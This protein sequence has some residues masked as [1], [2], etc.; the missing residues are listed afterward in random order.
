[1]PNT[2]PIPTKVK[3]LISELVF[4]PDRPEQ[5]YRIFFPG[6]VCGPLT[7]SFSRFFFRFF[8]RHQEEK[9]F[10]FVDFA[11]KK[12]ASH[13]LTKK[14]TF[15]KKRSKKVKSAFFRIFA[16]F[17][18]FFFPKILEQFVVFFFSWKSLHFANSIIF[19]AEKKQG[20]KKKQHFYSLIG[21]IPKSGQKQTFPGK[22]IR[23][24]SP[25]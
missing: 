22:K 14:M 4:I 23:Y 5:R 12:F 20:W 21:F 25:E 11:Q 16:V 24:L 9:T 8:P 2:A 3:N 7:H 15:P 13:S 10:F 17:V 1:M 6:V 18:L 19:R